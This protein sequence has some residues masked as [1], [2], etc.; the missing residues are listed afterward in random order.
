MES[1]PVPGELLN[2]LFVNRLA[3]CQIPSRRSLRN[4]ANNLKTFSR[5]AAAARTV[6]ALG[7]AILGPP[8]LGADTDVVIN[9]IMYHPPFDLDELQYVELFNRGQDAVDLSRWTFTKGI[10]FVFPARTMLAAGGSLVVCRNRTVFAANYGR[11]IAVAGDFSG[12]LRHGGEKIELCNA[13]GKV[14]DAV[15]YSDHAPWPRGPDGLSASLE[16]ICPFA[17]SQDADNWATSSLPV[18]EKPA[19]T[20]GRKNDSYSPHLPPTIAKVEFKPPGPQQATTVTAEVADPSGIKEV[21]L[22]YGLARTGGETPATVVPMPRVAGHER[23][24][25]YRAEIP[26]QP[27]GSLVRFRIKAVATSGGLR[28]SPPPNEPQPT[29]SFSTYLNT[30][31]ARVPFAYALNI[32]QP[33]PEIQIPLWNGQ[34]FQVPAGP[35]R[36]NGAFIYVPPQGGPVQ[37]FD[38]VQVH[39]RG[40]GFKVHFPKG[41]SFKGMSGVNVIFEGPPRYVLAEPLAYELYRRAGVP[42]PLAEHARVWLDGRLLGYQLLIEQ[43]NKAFLTRNQRDDTGFL[44]KLIWQGSGIVGQHEKK[45]RPASGYDDLTAVIQGLDRT[46]GADQWEFIRT[47]FNVAECVNYYAVNM[48]IQNWDGFHNNYFAYHDTGGTGRWEI[49]PWDEDKTWGDFDGAP[50]QYDWY[51]MPLTTGM[52]GDRSPS[53]D[54]RSRGN[55]VPG[56]FGGVSWWRAGG[57]LSAPLLAN[58]QFRQRFLARL[59]ELCTTVFTED[60]FGPVIDDLEK[61]LEPEVTLRAQAARQDPQLALGLFRR[62]IQSFRNQLKH[63]RQFILSA[64][65]KDPAS[66]P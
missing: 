4:N 46:S 60:K 33:R 27:A 34:S 26:G 57:W 24:G 7:L 61:R 43:P 36:G 11:D 5:I 62:D 39:S 64:I 40:G 15:N 47:N 12:R 19:G 54:G 28:W 38:H 14:V 6:R 13:A 21:T 9:E 31:T 29:Y 59:G 41:N 49:Y 66:R 65:P 18:M 63:R 30:N 23:K 45:T 17:P 1:G 37:T 3:R 32:S 10:G 51:E 55:N 56:W 35:T 16:R 25:I 8:L 52:K 50:L 20:P 42:A 53:L 48:C 44:Y 22:L 58:P 2:F